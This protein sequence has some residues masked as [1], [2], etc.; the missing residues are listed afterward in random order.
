MLAVVIDP[1]DQGEIG[2]LVHDRG[3]E[4]CIWSVGDL[5]GHFLV[6]PYGCKGQ[7]ENAVHFRQHDND[8]EPSRMKVWI[9]LPGKEPS[10]WQESDFVLDEGWI[11]IF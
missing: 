3:K 4:E 6:L 10:T 9:I 7:W 2:W 5:I 8:P 11:N 1:D